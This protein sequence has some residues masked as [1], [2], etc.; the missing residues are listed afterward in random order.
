AD[1]KDFGLRCSPGT[2]RTCA[3]VSITTTKIGSFSTGVHIRIRNWAGS[4]TGDHTGGSLI[5][6]IGIVAPAGITSSSG[7]HVTAG[8]GATTHGNPAPNW[9]IETPGGLG[10]MIELTAGITPGSRNGGIAGCLAPY[11]GYGATYFST[12]AP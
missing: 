2:L 11:G 8:G 9:F 6:R 3:N 7:L 4:Y 5:N 10:N 1:F 12:C